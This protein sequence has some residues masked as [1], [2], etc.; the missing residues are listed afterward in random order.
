LRKKLMRTAII[1]VLSAPA[2]VVAACGDDDSEDTT[3]DDRDASR[4]GRSL[5]RAPT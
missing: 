2:L 1:A 3:R 4:S 5:L